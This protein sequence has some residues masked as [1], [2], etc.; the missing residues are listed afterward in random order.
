MSLNYSNSVSNIVCIDLLN[1]SRE[2]LDYYCLVTNKT[3]ILKMYSQH[4]HSDLH[5]NPRNTLN[6]HLVYFENDYILGSIRYGEKINKFSLGGL[7][8]LP[9]S[10]IDKMDKNIFLLIEKELYE[11]QS[12][13][14]ADKHLSL[15]NNTFKKM[16]S[17]K[18]YDTTFI[19]SHLE[20][21]DVLHLNYNDLCEKF[22]LEIIFVECINEP[23]KS[24]LTLHKIYYKNQLPIIL[25][26]TTP[27]GLQYMGWNKSFLTELINIKPV[28]TSNINKQDQIDIIL[29]KINQTG[30]TSLDADELYVL[31]NF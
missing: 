2:Y 27:D 20:I 19:H 21:A 22:M 13:Q 18:K 4:L 31:Q 23:E 15:F 7:E 5:N 3:T 25:I 6:P 17:S 24:Q 10:G 16:L 29:D 14:F 9:D 26:F 8:I 28:Q 11:N 30:I 12:L 1:I